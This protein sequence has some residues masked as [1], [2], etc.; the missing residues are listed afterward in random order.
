M[1]KQLP[2]SSQQLWTVKQFDRHGAGEGVWLRDTKQHM[3]G[4]RH[5]APNSC[6]ELIF[7]AHSNGQF[8]TPEKLLAENTF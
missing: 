1:E 7:G 2:V 3:A 4:I 6:L 8:L 5:K